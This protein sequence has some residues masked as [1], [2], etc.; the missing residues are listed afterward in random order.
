MMTGRRHRYR[1][2]LAGKAKQPRLNLGCFAGKRGDKASHIY[3]FS[4]RDNATASRNPEALADID[5]LSLPIS[6]AV[7]V[8]ILVTILVT[9]SISAV[10]DAESNFRIAAAAHVLGFGTVA[11]RAVDANFE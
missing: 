6:I 7:S 4:F 3:G 11:S 9:V 10:A 8:P 1:R 2:Q 5:Q